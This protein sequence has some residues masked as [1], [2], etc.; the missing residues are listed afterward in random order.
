MKMLKV[1]QYDIRAPSNHE[2]VTLLIKVQETGKNDAC[3]QETFV[4][5][6]V[7]IEFFRRELSILGKKK[8]L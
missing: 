6:S 2:K 8:Q 1:D 7:E 3:F 5:F 4:Y